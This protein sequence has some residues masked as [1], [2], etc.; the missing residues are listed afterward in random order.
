MATASNL[1]PG[2]SGTRAKLLE[3]R[4]I[5]KTSGV[6]AAERALVDLLREGPQTPQAFMALARV[7]MKQR[8]FEDAGRAAAKAKT[9]APLEAE[10]LVAQ[11]LVSLR[12]KD[13]S[14]AAES[15]GEA[16]RLDP[17]S[18][19][20]HLGAAAVKM[21]GE[22]YEDALFLCDKVLD[23]DPSMEQAHE[24]LARIN[25]KMGRK[26]QAIIELKSIVEKNSENKRALRAYVRL[27]RAEDRG[28]EALQFLA[29][30]AEANPGDKRRAQRL[31]RVGARSGHAEYATKQYEDLVAQGTPRGTDKVRYTVALIQAGELDKARAM[32]ES[33]GSQKVMKPV[34]AKLQGDIALKT[35]DAVTATKQYQAACRAAKVEMLSPEAEAAAED[36]EAKAKLW[37]AHAQK[38]I[39]SAVRG[40]RAAAV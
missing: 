10:P 36:P 20:A 38:S 14:A 8:K 32:V 29:D 27:T 18:K 35:G 24:L 21:A 31:S 22:S 28:D 40:R 39:L 26:D 4:E 13:L 6:S 33:L 5:E 19:R 2:S 3:I 9:L 11:G 16:I 30:D 7:L 37:R 25:L 1:K 15:F 12:M 23:L 34:I 17:N